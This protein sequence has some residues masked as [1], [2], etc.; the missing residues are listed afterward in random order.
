MR[1][2]FSVGGR[3]EEKV[4]IFSWCLRLLGMFH[5]P[6]FSAY[7]LL[8]FFLLLLKLLLLFCSFLNSY[9]VGP[10]DVFKPD[11]GFYAAR[12]WL[13]RILASLLMFLFHLWVSF[14]LR[15]EGWWHHKVC[16]RT[17][18]PRG[19]S[20]FSPHLWLSHSVWL[21]R[22]NEKCIFFFK[23]DRCLIN[24]IFFLLLFT[25][26]NIVTNV[27][28]SFKTRD[29]WSSSLDWRRSKKMFLL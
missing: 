19:H 22:L 17:P 25:K 13:F 28:T 18:R 15:H 27:F 6:N 11:A 23:L 24:P 29:V 21:R 8:P 4:N 5:D 2:G 3:I 10:S 14:N 26:K 1:G 20:V 16:G 12:I 7:S 9:L